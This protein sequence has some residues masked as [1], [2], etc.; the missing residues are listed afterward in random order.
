MEL[1]TSFFIMIGFNTEQAQNHA[2]GR[3]MTGTYLM[4]QCD[5]DALYRLFD[6]GNMERINLN[7]CQA[8]PWGGPRA[9]VKQQQQS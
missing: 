8:G 3:P 6:N 1:S 5:F 2:Q 7:T 4:N 9:I